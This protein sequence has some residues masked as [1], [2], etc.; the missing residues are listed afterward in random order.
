LY[1]KMLKLKSI[2]LNRTEVSKAMLIRLHSWYSFQSNTK[3]F[4]SKRYVTPG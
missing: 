2:D 1:R 3:N 4:L